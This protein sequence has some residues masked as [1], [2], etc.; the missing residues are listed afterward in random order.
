[1]RIT[2]KTQKVYGIG[3]RVLLPGES[4]NI[5]EEQAMSE[6]VRHFIKT[7][8]LAVEGDEGKDAAPPAGGKKGDTTGGRRST[9]GGGKGKDKTP[10][11]APE[12][13]DDGAENDAGA[14]ADEEGAVNDGGAPADEGDTTGGAGGDGD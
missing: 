8:K 3:N 5:T 13:D 12:D 6:M 14:G 2:N 7:G 1:M 9:K 10:P 11:P 4:S